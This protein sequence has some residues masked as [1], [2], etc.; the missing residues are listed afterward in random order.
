MDQEVGEVLISLA[1]QED[2]EDQED[3]EAQGE[4]G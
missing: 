3:Q 1:E 4:V 2:Q